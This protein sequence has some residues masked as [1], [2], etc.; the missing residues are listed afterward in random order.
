M[1]SKG[2]EYTLTSG[3]T[4][5]VSVS[6][7][8]KV[9]ALHDALGAELRGRGVGS[10]DIGK[11]QQ[12]IQAKKKERVA[13]AAGLPVEESTEGDDGLNVIVDKIL[14]VATSRE[15]KA[16]LFSCAEKAVYRPDGS[17][18]SSIQFRLGTPGYGVFDNPVCMTQAREDFYDIC[19]AVAE[20]NL[21]PF[22]KALFSMFMA[23]VGSSADT[24]K[25][26]TE[27]A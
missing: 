24:Q 27:T 17:E 13:I 21:R 15:F 5:L 12:A 25:S 16:A 9:M 7:Y 20:E 10:L 19:K 6:E 14:A 26:H 2:K 11:I 8:E 22:G 23:H 4:L 3:A 1:D 18:A